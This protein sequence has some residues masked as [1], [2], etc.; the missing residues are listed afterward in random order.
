[1]IWI[2]NDLIV[3]G[4]MRGWIVPAL[5]AKEFDAYVLVGDLWIRYRWSGSESDLR[6]DMEVIVGEMD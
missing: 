3:D 1:V 5:Y 6:K 4:K 2:L